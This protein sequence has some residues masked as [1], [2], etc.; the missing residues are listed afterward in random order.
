[1]CDLSLSALC[2]SGLVSVCGFAAGAVGILARRKKEPSKVPTDCRSI[3]LGW[4]SRLESSFGNLFRGVGSGQFMRDRKRS[5]HVRA[6]AVDSSKRDLQSSPKKT[7]DGLR[8]SQSA[9]SG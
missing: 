3:Q 5:T 1:M 7:S 9:V 6:Q 8:V 2:G 4:L